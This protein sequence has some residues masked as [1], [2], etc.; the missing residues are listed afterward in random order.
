VRPVL[1]AAG[2]ATG[3]VATLLLT[4]TVVLGTMHSGRASSSSWPRFALHAV[5]R[6]MSLL[7]I[8]FVLVHV[9]I[10]TIK[11]QSGLVWWYAVV[12]YSSV[13][14]P[15]WLGMGTV[16]LDLMLAAIITSLLRVRIGLRSWRIVHVVAYASWPL[17]L[18]HGL[19]IGAAD[20]RL[21]WVLAVYISCVAAVA[22][23]LTRR[24]LAVDPDRDARRTVQAG[25]R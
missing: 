8:T 21:G 14:H 19:G 3:L 13:P 4:A 25:Q 17:A 23:A 9:V 2:H 20:R 1:S 11:P 6:N 5:H 7:A 24:F 22:A 16:A 10:A 15:F 12:P 18:A